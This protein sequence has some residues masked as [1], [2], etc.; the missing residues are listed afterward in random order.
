M[1]S[2]KGEN[3]MLDSR[4][5]M[6]C[7]KNEA[8]PEWRINL[9]GLFI[10]EKQKLGFDF[11]LGRANRQVGA[12]YRTAAKELEISLLQL[13]LKGPV[14]EHHAGQAILAT[15][16]G[17]QSRTVVILTALSFAGLE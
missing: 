11:L 5:G 12:C 9:D 14:G 10:R 6:E 16:G 13:V 8:V 15:N 3:G 17:S 1:H 7:L 2:R 4:F